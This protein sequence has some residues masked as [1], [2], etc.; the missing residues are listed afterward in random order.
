MKQLS[1]IVPVYNV[2]KYIRSCLESIYRQGL[3]E[4]C[5]EVI[6][7]NDGTM[8]NSMEMI[9]DI[10]CQHTNI[11]IINQANQGLSMA[12]NNGIKKATGNYIIF[13]DSDDLL[14]ENCLSTLLMEVIESDAD[15]FVTDFIRMEDE[16]INRYLNTP[17]LLHHNHE[18]Q[19]KTG[20]TLFM[21]DL[22]P[23][24]CYV[25]R[26]IYSRKF[27]VN[28]NIKYV[29]S[30]CFEDIPFTHECYLKAGKCIRAHFPM[31]IYRIG[32]AS[33]TKKIN[34]KTGKDLGTAIAKT[35]ELRQQNGLSSEVKERLCDNVFAALSV[36]LYAITHD[37]QDISDKKDIIKHLKE[38]APDLHFKHGMKQIFVNF[39]FQ[40]IPYAYISIRSL[41]IRF[42]KNYL[43]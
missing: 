21:E 9:K 15:L 42:S 28:N 26:T 39:L 30:I 29:P 12:R 31:Y 24:E 32:N 18:I 3:E 33:I 40:N 36:L 16:E 13:L 14:V 10:V 7:V 20:R 41:F 23:R 17:I 35:W 19:E 1:I 27:L 34:K 6:I 5:Y 22:N 43:R 38:T 2:E 25:W 8:D 11:E 37:I 4:D